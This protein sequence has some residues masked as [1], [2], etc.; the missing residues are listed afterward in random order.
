MFICAKRNVILPSPDGS[1]RHP[2]P[3]GFVGEIPGWAACTEYFQG[4]VADG[5]IV[6]PAA[7]RDKDL[8][9]AEEKPAKVRR[10]KKTTEE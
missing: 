4:L 10:G 9:Q 1:Q 2:V 6:L 3:R 5:K 8:Q 7:R